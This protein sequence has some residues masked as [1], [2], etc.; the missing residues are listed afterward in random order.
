MARER[1][2]E[3]DARAELERLQANLAALS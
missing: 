3:Q 2:K 1:Q